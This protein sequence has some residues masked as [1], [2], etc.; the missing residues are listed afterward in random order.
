MEKSKK[1]Y[2]IRFNSKV[3]KEAHDIFIKNAKKIRDENVEKKVE[4]QTLR[5]EIGD[6]CWHYDHI[7]EFLQSLKDA[8]EYCFDHMLDKSRMRVVGTPYYEYVVVNFPEKYLMDSVF[9]IFEDNKEFCII[10][11]K[12]GSFKIFIG[13]GHNKQWEELKNHLKEKHRYEIIHYETTSKAGTT[14]I[15]TLENMLDKSSFALLVC[16][17][18]DIDKD[19]NVHI[20]ENVIHELGLFQGRLGFDKAIILL[21]EGV[22]E[23]SNISGL[24]Q[25]RFTKGNIANIFGDIISEINEV[26]NN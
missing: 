26:R 25:I 8:D 13:H 14:T 9:Q 23:F 20:R 11:K 10:E 18:E 1:Y 5:I 2:D 24:N 21:E 22:T 15:S 17:G 4:P 16:T 12:E 7:E 3:I 6:E 19:G